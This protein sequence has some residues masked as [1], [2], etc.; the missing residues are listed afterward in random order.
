M[1]SLLSKIYSLFVWDYPIL[2]DTAQ[3]LHTF[4]GIS[5]KI[6]YKAFLFHMI[7]DLQFPTGK[8]H[9]YVGY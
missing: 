4:T 6:Q 1:N 8:Q 3:R 5:D 9:Y 2:S 7:Q